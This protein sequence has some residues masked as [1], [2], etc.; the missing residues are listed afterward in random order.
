M[1]VPRPLASHVVIILRGSVTDSTDFLGS[2]CTTPK[3]RRP[4]PQSH[5]YHF[6]PLTMYITNA[7]TTQPGS[8]FPE[9]ATRTC[10]GFMGNS[11][12]LFARASESSSPLPNTNRYPPRSRSMVTPAERWTRDYK[13][14]RDLVYG[15]KKTI[16]VLAIFFVP[17]LTSNKFGLSSVR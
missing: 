15:T 9:R 3:I 2:L 17:Y 5:A 12:G 8:G 7:P 11:P 16:L 13:G 4:H 10:L 6:V 14:T 1:C